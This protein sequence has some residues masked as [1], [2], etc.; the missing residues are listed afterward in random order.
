MLL[1]V[2]AGMASV[3]GGDD[4]VA[5]ARAFYVDNT[6]VVLAAQVVGL[7]AVAPLLLFVRGLARSP[8]VAGR[9]HVRTTGVLVAAAAVVTAVPPLWL[10]AVAGT[11]PADTV[12]RWTVASDLV[13]VLLFVA[14]A[15][16]AAACASAVPH[17]GWLRWVGIVVA[18]ACLGRALVILAGGGLLTVVAPLGFVGL[19]CVLSVLL[20]R[21][22]TPRPPNGI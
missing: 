17:P 22:F 1:L 19:V 6:G 12:H 14:I 18:A 20:L 5:D 9:N 21:G 7:V 13:D 2:G 16:F 8:L 10:C 4:T 3:P 11:A 15:G